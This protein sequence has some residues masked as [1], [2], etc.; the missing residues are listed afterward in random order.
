MSEKLLAALAK[1]ESKLKPY[2]APAAKKASPK[3]TEKAEGAEGS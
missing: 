1:R 2:K 3:K